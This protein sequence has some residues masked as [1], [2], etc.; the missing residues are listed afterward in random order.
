MDQP[1]KKQETINEICA[2]IQTSIPMAAD[3]QAAVCEFVTT[4]INGDDI[5]SHIVVAATLSENRAGVLVYVLTNARALKFEIDDKTIGVEGPYLKDIVSVNRKILEDGRSQ[6]EI[7]WTGG[8]YGLRYPASEK[9][10]TD[11]F[12]RVEQ[13]RNVAGRANG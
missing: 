10:V 6:F 2:A 9:G 5:V 12:L 11:F 1:T 4:T 13:V 8:M 3:R 7:A